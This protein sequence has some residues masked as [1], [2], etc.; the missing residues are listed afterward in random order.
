MRDLSV[1]QWQRLLVCSSHT[2][3]VLWG[4]S[5]RNTMDLEIGSLGNILHFKISYGEDWH[6]E[7]KKLPASQMPGPGKNLAVSKAGRLSWPKTASPGQA[8]SE[9]FHR[10]ASL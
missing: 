8:T 1:W 9:I 6:V 10:R 3:S 5:V 2:L 7:Q 4:H